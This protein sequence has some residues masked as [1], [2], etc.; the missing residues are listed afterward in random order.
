MRDPQT[1][2][3]YKP[4]VNLRIWRNSIGRDV[5]DIIGMAALDFLLYVIATLV[6][7]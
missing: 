2:Q 5:L 3:L 4:K 7:V 1:V 6:L